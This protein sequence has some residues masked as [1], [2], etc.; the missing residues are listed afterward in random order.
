MIFQHPQSLPT[1]EIVLFW[2]GYMIVLYALLGSGPAIVLLREDQF[3]K[4]F[5]FI[6]GN[7]W[8]VIAAKFIS[9]LM[10]LLA[11]VLVLDVLCSLFFFLP[12]FTL[13]WITLAMIFICELPIYTF[14]LLFAVLNIRQETIQPI[15]NILIFIYIALTWNDFS[16]IAAVDYISTM[17]NPIDYASQIGRILLSSI[18]SNVTF[19]PPLVMVLATSIYLII[20]IFS[21]KRIKILPIFRN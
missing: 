19:L 8:A 4:Q 7:R 11:S 18:F 6:T 14:F 16:G 1:M 10:V 15:M 20:G 12:F 5:I 3:L 17:V 21:L 2:T 13:L 9:Q